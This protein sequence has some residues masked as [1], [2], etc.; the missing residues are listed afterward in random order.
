MMYYV[1]FEGRVPGVYEEWEECKKQVHKFSGNCYKGYPTRHE[2]V[3]KWRAHQAKKSKMK[4]FL[5]LSLLLTIVAAKLEDQ[6]ER[7][8]EDEKYRILDWSEDGCCFYAADEDTADEYIQRY[9]RHRPY[10]GTPITNYAQMKTI[11]TPRFVYRSQ[12][13]QPNLLVRAIDF[14]ADNEEQYAEYRKLHPSEERTWLRTWLRTQFP[15]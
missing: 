14:I 10:V 12:L 8:T 1:V 7:H 11:F 13:F 2:A 3:A 9:P 15:A 5:V 4:T 6:V